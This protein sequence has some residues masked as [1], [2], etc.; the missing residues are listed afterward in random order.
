MESLC[1]ARTVQIVTHK[2]VIDADDR[3]HAEWLVKAL[4]NDGY[5]VHQERHEMVDRGGSIT[6]E[7][8]RVAE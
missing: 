5:R 6:I 3:E 4:R 2:V 7:Q 1:E 8:H